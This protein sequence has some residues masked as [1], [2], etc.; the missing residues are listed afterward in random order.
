[1]ALDEDIVRKIK[2][3]EAAQLALGEAIAACEHEYVIV[4]QVDTIVGQTSAQQG[5]QV[6]VQ[7]CI[8]GKCSHK[9]KTQSI[10]PICIDCKI[11]LTIPDVRNVRDN[12]P[13]FE[14]AF[15]DGSLDI[16]GEFSGQGQG[17]RCLNCGKAHVY[18]IPGD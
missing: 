8:C 6:F 14:A 7:K 17:Y 15:G 10:N 12:R 16:G 5:R 1:M 4:S 18:R 9:T 3:V 2:A 11:E 13:E